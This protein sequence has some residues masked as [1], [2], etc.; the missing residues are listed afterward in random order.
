MT[1][2]SVIHSAIIWGNRAYLRLTQ[3]IPRIDNDLGFETVKQRITP[4][5]IPD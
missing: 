3:G 2:E 4:R 5:S 1:E